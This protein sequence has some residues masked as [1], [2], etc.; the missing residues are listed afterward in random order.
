MSAKKL[1]ESLDKVVHKIVMD[2]EV[3]I[4]FDFKNE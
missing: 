3:N 2:E 4:K 1:R